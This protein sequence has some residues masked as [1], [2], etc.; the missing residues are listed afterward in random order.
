MSTEKE[1]Y[2][3]EKA[4]KMFNNQPYSKRLETS[5]YKYSAQIVEL[6]REKQKAQEE[7]K[8]IGRKISNIREMLDETLK[9][10]EKNKTKT[11]DQ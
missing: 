2:P 8:R 3:E 4:R 7:V 5:A 10:M 9:E 1:N 6:Q 11:Q